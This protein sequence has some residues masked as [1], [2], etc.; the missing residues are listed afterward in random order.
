MMFRKLISAVLL[1]TAAVRC[2]KMVPEKG[3]SE[4]EVSGGMGTELPQWEAY[5]G[6]KSDVLPGWMELPAVSEIEG[7]A[8][9]YHDMV[10]PDVYTGRNYSIFYDASLLM[11]RWVAYP[12]TP[13]L[14]GS[15]KR[16]DYWNQWDPKIPKEFQPTTQRGGWGLKGYHKGHMLPSGDRVANT[17]ANHQTFYPT[18]MTVQWGQLN[19]RIWMEL[20][21][22]ARAWSGQ[23]DTLY[24]VTG[25]V[26]SDDVHVDRGGKE[27]NIPAGYYKVLLKYSKD[28]PVSETYSGIAFYLDNRSYV[29]AKVGG[30]MAMP[31]RDLEKQLGMNFFVNLPEEYVGYAETRVVHSDWGL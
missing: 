27:V 1:V 29:Q 2:D 23:C 19:T 17:E 7:C 6:L 30:D 18:N 26:P 15:G 25:A 4:S 8:W 14:T 28:R 10:I 12:M 13:D 3:A 9:V 24:V 31:I 20:E 21:K 16:S 22:S 11:P 5:P